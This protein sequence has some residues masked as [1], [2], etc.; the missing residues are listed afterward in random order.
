MKNPG[1]KLIACMKRF[2]CAVAI[3][4]T[5]VLCASALLQPVSAYAASAA[6][7]GAGSVATEQ[8]NSSEEADESEGPI[9]SSDDES[10]IP[11][12]NV[13]KE[14][15]VDI[16]SSDDQPND[17]PEQEGV[18]GSGPHVS[19]TAHVSNVGWL[20]TVSDGATA[21][22]TGRSLSLEAVKVSLSNAEASGSI[23]V[24]AHVSGIGW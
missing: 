12:E 11:L 22:T 1:R 21:G 4:L 5:Y 14:Q 2:N 16:S 9:E 8:S 13:D 7:E 19:V 3:L 17:N 20:G 23:G 18:D 6:G 15:P 24:N 10:S